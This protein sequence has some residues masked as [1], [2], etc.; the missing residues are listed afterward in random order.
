M[1]VKRVLKAVNGEKM[2]VAI[3]DDPLALPDSERVDVLTVRSHMMTG[4]TSITLPST[5]PVEPSS[6]WTLVPG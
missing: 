5:V 4:R 3:V 1:L 2:R 6:F